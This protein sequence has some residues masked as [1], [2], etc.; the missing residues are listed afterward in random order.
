MKCFTNSCAS[1]VVHLISLGNFP[2]GSSIFF[3]TDSANMERKYTK[4]NGFP[5]KGS[6]VLCGAACSLTSVQSKSAIFPFSEPCVDDQGVIFLS[7]LWSSRFSAGIFCDGGTVGSR[8][9]YFIY[10]G[11]LS[12]IT[13]TPS[14]IISLEKG[15]FVMKRFLKCVAVLDNTKDCIIW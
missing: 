13:G 1:P 3:S 12:N 14:R 7:L 2:C 15:F 4:F 11:I 5:S 8:V 9:H 6:I 10:K